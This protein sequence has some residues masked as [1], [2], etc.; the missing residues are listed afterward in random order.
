[1]SRFAPNRWAVLAVLAL[2]Q[3][4]VVLDVTIV[5]V[6][7]PDIQR[8]LGFSSEDL[9]WVVSAYTLTFGG[10][11]L[12]GGRAADLLGRRSV[13]LA[14]LGLFTVSSLAAGLAPSPGALIAARAVQGLGGAL[15]S[16]AA[17]SILTVTFP[18]G[19]ERNIALGL[20]GALAG[21][22]GTLG[23]IAGGVLVDALGW[24]AVFF[25]NVPIGV[26]LMAATPLLVAESRV[27]RAPGARR[28]FD[29]AGAVLGTGGLLA[30]VY[31]VIRAE[32]LGFGSAEV[33]GLFAAAAALLAG[34]IA[35]EARSSAPLVPLRLFRIPSLRS[36]SPALALNGAA[37]LAMFFLTAIF[38]QQV[39]GDSALDAGL[40]FLP[41]GIAAVAG[42]TIASTLVTRIGTRPVHVGGALLSAAGLL[43]LAR[44]GGDAA[45]ATDLLPGFVLFGAGITGVGVAN[46]I[47]AISEVRHEEAGAASGVVTAAFQVGGALGLAVVTTLANSRASD[48]LAAGASQH[49]ALVDAYH[50]GLLIAALL[51]VVNVG[52]GLL[53]RQIEPAP[54]QLQEAHAAA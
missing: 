8:S 5:N 9:T 52:I 24:E 40:H 25:V 37:F 39:R 15:L 21:L 53:S 41:M 33:L 30:L 45:Y 11:L 7:L 43:L 23:V 46:Q 18:H 35:V 12:L 51:A 27:E 14:G 42:A 54:E 13:F 32:P 26:L 16:P 36:A 38:L 4:M 22:G 2:A 49:A 1:M 44:A 28:E 19:R 10:F 34:F 20:W 48:A 29:A 6:A 31:G 50:R 17:L 3:F 47:A